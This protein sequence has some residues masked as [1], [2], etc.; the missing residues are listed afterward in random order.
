MLDSSFNDVYQEGREENFI[1][2][3]ELRV[4]KDGTFEELKALAVKGGASPGQYKQPR[5]MSN[6]ERL[7]LLNDKTLLSFRS[8]SAIVRPGLECNI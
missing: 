2:P 8:T 7:Q 5:S 1:G 3:I 6:P 4:I